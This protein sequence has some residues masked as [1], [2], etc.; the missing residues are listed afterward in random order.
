MTDWTTDE[1]D[2]IGDAEELQVS[3]RRRDDSLRPFITIWVVRVGDDLYLRS[4]YGPD[5]GWFRRALAS[6]S[7]AVRAGG[8]ERDV[9]FVHLDS[10]DPVHA[11]I[12]S[13]YHAKY[14]SH[15]PRIVGTVVGDAVRG[16]TL[17]I[18]AA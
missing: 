5:N 1:L 7:G 14:D 3:S 2:R 18:D 4:A 16:T 6:G 11:A 9:A 8:I 10:D 12:D 15:G 13:A 17:R